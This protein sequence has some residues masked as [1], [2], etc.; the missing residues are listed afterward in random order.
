MLSAPIPLSSLPPNETWKDS[1][2][3]L[4]NGDIPRLRT[5]QSLDCATVASETKASYKRSQSA[6][7]IT[8]TVS[9]T[10]RRV[11]GNSSPV[12]GGGQTVDA[13]TDTDYAN[14]TESGVPLIGNVEGLKLSMTRNQARET[15][16]GMHMHRPLPR[17]PGEEIEFTV[18][19]LPYG[20]T[21]Q[22]NPEILINGCVNYSACV[23]LILCG[24]Q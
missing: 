17:L 21:G 2:P 3:V 4:H 8:R 13:Q 19:D 15:N 23:S 18:G 24:C 22:H 1:S 10:H 11:Q 20:F 12:S 9:E 7:H 16:P 6:K 14:L 5:P